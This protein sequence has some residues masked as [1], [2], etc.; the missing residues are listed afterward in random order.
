MV[1]RPTWEKTVS[2]RRRPCSKKGTALETSDLVAS[3]VERRGSGWLLCFGNQ[4]LEL[5][6]RYA[7]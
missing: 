4:G 5:C 6:C 3:W 2:F 1:G 7:D